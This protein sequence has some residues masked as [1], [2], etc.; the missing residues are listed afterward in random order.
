MIV[1]KTWSRLKFVQKILGSLLNFSEKYFMPNLRFILAI[2]HHF[3]FLVVFLILFLE[4][5]R[6]SSFLTW[7]FYAL[8]SWNRKKETSLFIGTIYKHIATTVTY[9]LNNQN[10]NF[11][12][13]FLQMSQ[14]SCWEWSIT[15]TNRGF[16]HLDLMLMVSSDV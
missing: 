3:L 1:L 5:K 15:S 2:G 8:L 11:I 9:M 6:N 13:C 14:I 10:V 12:V 7:H 4:K 16:F